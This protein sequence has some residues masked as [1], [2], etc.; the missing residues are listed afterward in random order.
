MTKSR[1]SEPEFA[2][3]F[4]DMSYKWVAYQDG[5]SAKERG[6]RFMI[7]HDRTLRVTRYGDDVKTPLPSAFSISFID[8]ADRRG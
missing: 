3:L 2:R 4:I 8:L 1:I 6:A 7:E 5:V